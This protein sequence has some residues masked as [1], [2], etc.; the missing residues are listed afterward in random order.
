MRKAMRI[1]EV[2]DLLG[3]SKSEL[4]RQLGVSRQAINMW[5]DLI[6]VQRVRGIVSLSRGRIRPS[7]LRPDIF[8]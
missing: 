8:A 6:P 2:I 5:K 1:N 3:I 4:S 7:E